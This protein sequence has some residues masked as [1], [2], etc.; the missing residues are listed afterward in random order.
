M[1][2]ALLFHSLTLVELALALFAGAMLFVLLYEEPA[3][4]RKF[5]AEYEDYCQRVSRWIPRFRNKL[6]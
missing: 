4:R 6:S 3:L 5:G 2:E 1:G